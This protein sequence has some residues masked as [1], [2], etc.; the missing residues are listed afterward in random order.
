MFYHLS[1]KVCG[2]I[3][4]MYLWETQ[5][6]QQLFTK[7]IGIKCLIGAKTLY[8][9]SAG[10][11]IHHGAPC[12][13]LLLNSIEVDAQA[14]YMLQHLLMLNIYQNEITRAASCLCWILH[15][16]AIIIP[17]EGFDCPGS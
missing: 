14:E 8:H 15:V 9:Y 12:Q 16:L 13:V 7:V 2:K 5:Y 10:H 1:V 17:V 6:E 4:E 11:K 3:I